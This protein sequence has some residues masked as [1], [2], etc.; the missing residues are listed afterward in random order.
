MKAKT[1]R[2]AAGLT[3]ALAA[4]SPAEAQFMSSPYPVIVVPPPQLQNPIVPKPA[5]KR[6]Q[7]PQTTAPP[8]DSPRRDL[9]RCYQGR[10][11]VCP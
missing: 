6:D 11:N 3:L 7:P 5:P 9:G 1:A 10:T 8:P 4:N 2:L